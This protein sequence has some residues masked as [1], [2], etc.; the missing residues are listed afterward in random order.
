M[1]QPLFDLNGRT[2]CVGSGIVPRTI[3]D[4]LLRMNADPSHWQTPITIY[5]GTGSDQESPLRATDALLFSSVLSSIRSPVHT[6][7]LGMLRGFEALVLAAGQRG[8]RFLLPH[9]LV[10]IG[11]IQIGELQLPN[12]KPGLGNHTDR[13]SL[14]DQAKGLLTEEIDRIGQG[15][16]LPPTLWIVP[17]VLTANQAIVENIADQLVPRLARYQSPLN[18]HENQPAY[19]KH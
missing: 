9:A 16:G 7:G 6:V 4:A 11:E 2:V 19:S 13:L 5:L 8:H 3:I 12:G 18:L 15:F 17:R 10:C 14:R 1:Q